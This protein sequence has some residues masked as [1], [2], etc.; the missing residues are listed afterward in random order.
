MALNGTP[1]M[2]SHGRCQR[3]EARPGVIRAASRSGRG[4]FVLLDNARRDA[5]ALADCDAVVFRPRTD[6][7]A[8]LTAR[9]GTHRPAA[10][11]PSSLAGMF[12]VGRDLPAEPAGVLLAEVDLVVGAAEPEPQR[13]IRWASI[14][15]VFEFDSDPLRHHGLHDSGELS[16][17]YKIN[18]HPVITTTLMGRLPHQAPCR[19]SAGTL[20]APPGSGGPVAAH[21]SRTAEG[22]RRQAAGWGARRGASGRRYQA[23]TSGMERLKLLVEPLPATSSDWLDLH[24]MQEVRGSNPRSS[25]RQNIISQDPKPPV[26][27]YVL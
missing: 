27:S 4:G 12:N 24:G 15:V 18:R 14:K 11:S 20:T 1:L 9:C 21:Q 23:I 6:I 17:P 16:A 7:A 5:P 3:C 13:L 26:C 2:D 8:A 19:R 10:L 25:T 22:E